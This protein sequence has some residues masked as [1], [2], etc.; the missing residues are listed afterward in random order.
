M[1]SATRTTGSCPT[2]PGRPQPDY[3][4]RVDRRTET[5]IA[6]RTLLFATVG[7]QINVG[8]PPG[9]GSRQFSAFDKKT[10]ELLW[11]TQLEAGATGAPMTYLHRGTQYAVF[12]IGSQQHAA[13]FIA[14]ALP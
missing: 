8:T 3:A 7:D 1:R 5:V 12:A 13:E 4:G 6:T 9:F 2:A 10:G 11:T 14:F